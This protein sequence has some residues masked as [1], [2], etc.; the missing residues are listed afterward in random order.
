MQCP[1]QA[2]N[3]TVK[4][5]SPRV[6]RRGNCE[7]HQG[8]RAERG[9]TNLHRRRGRCRGRRGTTCARNHAIT[10]HDKARVT[11]TNALGRQVRGY[12]GRLF[13][14]IPD[15]KGSACMYWYSPSMYQPGE[16]RL[17]VKQTPTATMSYGP[18][19]EDC[20]F[21]LRQ[22][23]FRQRQCSQMTEGRYRVAHTCSRQSWT[24]ERK[25][26]SL[27]RV[28]WWS[29]PGV[30]YAAGKHHNYMKEGRLHTGAGTIAF[31]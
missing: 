22:T 11:A 23:P 25:R 17:G 15:E 12:W 13:E 6:G 26:P 29:G 27:S 20:P 30:A 7:E 18:I 21:W 2:T 5:G 31:K 14:F 8:K 3:T 10:Q 24:G 9:Q 16:R 28:Q 4:R 19:S 1:L